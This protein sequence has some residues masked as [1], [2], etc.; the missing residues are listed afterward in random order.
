M[1]HARDPALGLLSLKMKGRKNAKT[2]PI[3]LPGLVWSGLVWSG[4]LAGGFLCPKSP[5]FV[6]A[7]GPPGLRH[8]H[9]QRMSQENLVLFLRF[10]TSKNPPPGGFRGVRR[11]R[12]RYIV[13]AAAQAGGGH[14][15]GGPMVLPTASTC[16]NAMNISV[17]YPSEEQMERALY[18]AIQNTDTGM[19]EGWGGIVA[20]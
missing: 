5:P 10:W 11:E 7:E 1:R 14:G 13:C 16:F 9:T 19:H 12:E 2:P 4:A 15:P 18:Y 3:V 17:A 8:T 20:Q 6:C